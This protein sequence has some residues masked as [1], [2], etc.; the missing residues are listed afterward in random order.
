MPCPR[1][2]LS[3]ACH[4]KRNSQLLGCA[5]FFGPQSEGQGR[6][7][8]ED[9]GYDSS[10]LTRSFRAGM[11]DP[12]GLSQIGQGVQAFVGCGHAIRTALWL[13]VRQLPWT[14]GRFPGD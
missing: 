12:G 4:V 14:E 8:V 9:V 11:E 6:T 5:L 13:W 7:G 10:R 3:F 2:M 1:L